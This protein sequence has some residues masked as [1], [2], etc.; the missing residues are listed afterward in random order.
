M[1]KELFNKIE[2]QALKAFAAFYF[3]VY[4][5]FSALGLPKE[6]LPIAV[7]ESFEKISPIRAHKSLEIAIN[8]IAEETLDWS[9]N[10]VAAI[11]DELKK[12]SLLTIT[13]IRYRYSKKYIQI[14]KRNLI[15]S[16]QEYYLIK[17]IADSGAI[18]LATVPREQIQ[19]ML[20]NYEN[21]IVGRLSRQHK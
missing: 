2:Y 18:K 10:K 14:L 15:K 6:K 17:G 5:D 1:K 19:N 7:L 3:E 12:R 16:E 20:T 21:L 13:D 8:D 11:D 4:V 9:P